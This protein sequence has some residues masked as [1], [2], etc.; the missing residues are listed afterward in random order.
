MTCKRFSLQAVILSVNC[1]GC[2]LANGSGMVG[3]TCLLLT[4][5]CNRFPHDLLCIVTGAGFALWV[6]V[7]T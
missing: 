4:Q 1:C 5:R 7:G 3:G 2:Q 6:W